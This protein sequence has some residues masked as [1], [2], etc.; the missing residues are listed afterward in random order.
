MVLGRDDAVCRQLGTLGEEPLRIEGLELVEIRTHVP[1][2]VAPLELGG[3]DSPDIPLLR[4]DDKNV[5]HEVRPPL[6]GTESVAQWSC[7]AARAKNVDC[8]P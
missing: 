6:G 7:A 1:H 3:F 8:A 5:F 4:A 2:A